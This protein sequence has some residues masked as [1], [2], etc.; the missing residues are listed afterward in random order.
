VSNN[1]INTIQKFTPDGA[2]SVFARTGSDYVAEGLAFDGA[3]NLYAAYANGLGD[4]IEKLTPGGIG[5]VFAG[6]GPP[7]FESFA[8]TNDAGVPLRLPITA[9]ADFN[10]DGVVNFN[11]LL[12]L[13]Q[14]YGTKSGAT[15]QLGDAN[16]DGA[17]DFADLLL[18]S[19]EYQQA[20]GQ[21]AASTVPEPA[22]VAALL[23]P[24]LLL[25]RRAEC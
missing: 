16:G 4:H 22:C 10:G 18:L 20:A 24:M 25:R 15:P 8:F 12:V 17:V 19:Q 6:I 7:S 13:A 21:P 23:L 5:S 14:H 1:G 2:G 9:P 3:G 11:D